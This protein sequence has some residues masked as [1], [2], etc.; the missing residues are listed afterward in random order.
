MRPSHP[1]P[2]E[3]TLSAELGQEFG[4]VLK[5]KLSRNLYGEL[6]VNSFIAIPTSVN[7][8]PWSS[9]KF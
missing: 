4:A 3:P 2:E 1:P 7:T 9:S 8:S 5:D 6:D